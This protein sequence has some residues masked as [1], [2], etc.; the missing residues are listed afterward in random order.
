[1]L[2]TF[3]IGLRE[4]LEAALIVGIIAAFLGRQGRR[5]ALRRV[6]IGTAAA[7]VIC[8][9]VGVAL[10]V[11]SADLPQR[12]Q[13]GLETVVGLLAVAWSPTWSSG[14]AS[15]R[16]TCK[17]ELEGAAAS[18]LAPGSPGRWCSWPFSRCCARDSRPSSSC[19]PRF[20]PAATRRHRWLGALSASSLR[21][22][23]VTDLPGRRPA[24]PVEFFRVTGLVLVLVAA[25][26]VMTALHTANE[27]GWLT[28][29]Q[30]QRSICPG[31]FV[32]VRR[33]R[34]S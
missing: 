34:R 31:W 2:P 18:A 8:M 29:G 25:G 3:V 7:M 24:Q 19:S 16:G 6:W 1:M 27:A 33:G 23:S 30:A 9:G 15:T 13:E 17:G 21:S 14:C 5:D 28:F 4:G 32:R 11:V 22:A 26:L 10:Q 20:T 12:Q